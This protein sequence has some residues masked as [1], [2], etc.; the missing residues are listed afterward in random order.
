MCTGSTVNTNSI[1]EIQKIQD[2]H[3]GIINVSNVTCVT[4]WMNKYNET[5][6]LDNNW[7]MYQVNKK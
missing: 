2:L 1:T 4:Q 5:E 3:G 7:D 6:T